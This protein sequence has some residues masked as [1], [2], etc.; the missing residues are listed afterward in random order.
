MLV[1]PPRPPANK[2]LPKNVPPSTSPGC[3]APATLQLINQQKKAVLY[4]FTSTYRVS[5]LGWQDG[6]VH[7]P[8]FETVL[9]VAIKSNR[10]KWIIPADC[11][12]FGGKDHGDDNCDSSLVRGPVVW[13]TWS[14]WRLANEGRV[15][16]EQEEEQQNVWPT[17]VCIPEPRWVVT[18]HCLAGIASSPFHATA[19][20]I[21]K[22]RTTTECRWVSARGEANN[23]DELRETWVAAGQ[24]LSSSSSGEIEPP[25][26]LT[27]TI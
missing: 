19:K 1:F 23:G 7:G 26:N 24:C 3:W 5:C 11:F 14:T 8:G 21:A 18:G 20:E 9:L 10:I 12:A 13:P 22:E 4:L 27:G 16:K 17:T 15:G 2:A 6:V 25:V